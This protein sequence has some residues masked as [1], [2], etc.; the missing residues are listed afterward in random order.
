MIDRLL[1]G[2]EGGRRTALM[3]ALAA[4]TWGFG[5]VSLAAGWQIGLI[6]LAVGVVVIVV[7][8]AGVSTTALAPLAPIDADDDTP[9]G[10]ASAEERVLARLAKMRDESAA[11]VES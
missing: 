9:E 1:R 8:R 5:I 2:A 7:L 10:L 4:T 11:T 6:A 3:V